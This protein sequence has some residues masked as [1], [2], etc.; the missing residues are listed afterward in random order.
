[1]ATQSG[2]LA[3][4]IAGTEEPVACY[5]WGHTESDTTDIDVAAAAATQTLN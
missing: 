2:I 3:G 1:M 4:R 5:L